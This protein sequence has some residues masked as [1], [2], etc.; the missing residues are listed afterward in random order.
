ML[1]VAILLTFVFSCTPLEE[2]KEK[3]GYYKP[4]EEL[5]EL[6][7]DVQMQ[8]IF[9]DSKTFVDCVP[10]ESPEII[11]TVYKE[12]KDNKGFDLKAF[13]KQNFEVPESFDDGSFKTEKGFRQHLEDHW[14]YLTRSSRE[15]PDNSTI[16]GLPE[17]YIVPGGR[18]R[19]IYYWDSYFSMIGLGVSGREDIIGS[20]IDNFSFLIDSIGYIPNGNRTYF[21]G[22]SQPPYY[23]AMI[24]LY[25]QLT[26]KEDALK[27]LTTLQKEYD[28][29]MNGSDTLS[30][31]LP[32]YKRVVKYKGAILNRYFDEYPEPRPESY[33][34]DVELAEA[35]SEGSAEELYLHLRSACESGWDFSS[36]WFEKNDDFSSIRTADILPVDLNS[37][38]YNMEVVLA[39]LYRVSG[40][41]S[42][43]QKFLKKAEARYNAINEL[44]WNPEASM[45]QDI[46]WTDSSFNEKTTL[47]SFY[48]MYFK[49]ATQKN[50]E[51][52]VPILLD[53]LLRDG[54]LITTTIESG[55]QWDAPNGWAPLQWIGFKGLEH[56]GYLEESESI[57]E[58][59]LKVNQKVFRNTGK[60]MEKYNVVDTTLVAGGGEY[61]NQD[62]FGW[63]N[64]VALGM[65]S[66]EVKY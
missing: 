16:I 14:E 25:A 36:R 10:K 5:G 64:G 55:Q 3:K 49:I 52:Q 11:L 65:L 26:S 50:A 56:Y 20:M 8:G 63:T 41:E 15:Y 45:F 31:E 7:K 35:K 54:G 62:G 37:L 57:K 53:S 17:K 47:A 30:L 24:N 38:M 43:A 18:F 59:W 61:P 42:S 27:Y 46:I 12:Q 34:E 29:W 21:L 51:Q 33:K 4:W 32:V 22:R 6:F 58:R 66:E 9:S 19:E 44:F 13:V 60:M 1:S 40:D 2:I 39:D 23:A 28:F 48:P